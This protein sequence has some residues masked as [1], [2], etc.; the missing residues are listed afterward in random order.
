MDSFGATASPW[1]G[2][3]HGQITVTHSLLDADKY[4]L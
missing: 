1:L 4:E 3:S 2:K